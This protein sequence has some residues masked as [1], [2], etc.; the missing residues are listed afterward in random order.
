MER[1]PE[2]QLGAREKYDHKN[3]GAV[4]AFAATAVQ[5]VLAMK[6]R[7]YWGL[8]LPVCFGAFTIYAWVDLMSI[9]INFRCSP[10]WPSPD[11][12]GEHF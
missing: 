2:R 4:R 3:M 1:G 8:I 6:C 7:W 10:H 5:I 11:L 9:G 12:A